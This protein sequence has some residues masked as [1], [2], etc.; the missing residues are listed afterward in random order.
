[1]VERG[2]KQ[3]EGGKWKMERGS[4]RG[5]KDDI[6]VQGPCCIAQFSDHILSRIDRLE[7][8]SPLD[9]YETLMLQMSTESQS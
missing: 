4:E 7:T 5:R 9:Q 1:M 6:L 2:E 3:G 8:P